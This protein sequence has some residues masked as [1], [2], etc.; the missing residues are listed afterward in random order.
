MG[1]RS[2]AFALLAVMFAVVGVFLWAVIRPPAPVSSE[3]Q[4][5]GAPPVKGEKRIAGAA[6]PWML[7]AWAV[8]GADR[9]VTVTVSARDLAERPVV[10]SASPTAVLRML[11]MAMAAERVVLVREGSGFWRGS[12]RLSM[13]GRWNLQ[14]EFNGETL[15]VPI[16][17]GARRERSPR[18]GPR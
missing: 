10:P 1:A 13:A 7:Y 5:A 14:V 8:P 16:E 18:E 4:S 17:I 15:N 3:T 2:S 12:A 6:G 11:D 9:A